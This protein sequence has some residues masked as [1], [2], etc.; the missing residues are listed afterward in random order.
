MERVVIAC[1]IMG[2]VMRWHRVESWYTV[3]GRGVMLYR[4]GRWELVPLERR[5]VG[6]YAIPV[7]DWDTHQVA[8]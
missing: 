3:E 1:T 6:V 5:H 7:D 8:L 4:D 2:P